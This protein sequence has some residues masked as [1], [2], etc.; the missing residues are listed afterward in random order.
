MNISGHTRLICLL[1]SPVAH[2][3]SPAMH[4]EGFRQLDLDYSYM[5]FD[6]KEGELG[7]ILNSFKKMGVRGFNLTMPLKTEAVSLCDRLSTAAEIAGSV[8]TV[9]IE[10]DGTVTGH[11]TDG[12]GFTESARQAGVDFTGKKVAILGT[13]GAGIAVLVQ[14]AL[15]GAKEISVFERTGSRFS[16]RTKAV[17]ETL[18]NRTSCSVK[19]Y[20]YTDEVLRKEISASVLLINATN[21]GMAPNVDGNLIKDKSWLTTRAEGTT[22]PLAVA[23]V[24]YNPRKT[25]LLEMAEECGLKAFNGMYMLLYQG[26]AAFEL[27]TGQKMPVEMVKEK[28]FNI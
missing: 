9:V 2:S 23:D 13:G 18:N 21:V 19:V 6:I 5:A 17:V 8:N 16:E 24:I 22:D 25:K 28:Y 3:L 27:W 12:I 10:E 15:D 7:G 14:L 20:D 4:N 26:A 11:T 1:G